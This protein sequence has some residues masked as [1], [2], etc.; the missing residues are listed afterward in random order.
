MPAGR[1]SSIQF[2]EGVP[3]GPARSPTARP[4]SGCASTTGPPRSGFVGKGR[5]ESPWFHH[6][7]PNG[8]LEPKMALAA[9]KPNHKRGQGQWQ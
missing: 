7:A 9:P 5:I 6:L 3:A 2:L 8:L 4:R 1:C